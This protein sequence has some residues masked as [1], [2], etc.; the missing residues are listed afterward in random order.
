MPDFSP[1]PRRD[2]VACN[3]LAA[4]LAEA[5]C[6]LAA[7]DLPVPLAARLHRQFIAVCDAV[8][9][10]G[11]DEAFGERRLAAFLATLEKAAAKLPT[12]GK[13]GDNS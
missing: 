13:H 11:A 6:R 8:K 4:R 2:A 3:A 10:A 1:P 9:A 5:R 12:P 7:L